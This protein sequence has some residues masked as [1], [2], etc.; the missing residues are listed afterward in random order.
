MLNHRLANSIPRRLRP[1]VR[2]AVVRSRYV[3]LRDQDA[4]LVSYPKSGSTWVRFLLTHA[5][6][7]QETDFD[8]VRRTFPPLG[9]Q[10]RAPSI[11]PGRGRA[12]RTH[13]PLATYRGAPGTPVIYLARDARPVALSYARHTARLLGRPVEPRAFV[14]EF[15]VGAVDSYGP[16]HRHVSDALA[17]GDRRTAPFIVVRFEDLEADTAGTVRRLLAFLGAEP[18]VDVDA[19]VA[20]NAADRM[21]AKEARSDR[22]RRKSRDGS[23]FVGGGGRVSWDEVVPLEQRAHFETVAGRSLRALGYPV[24]PGSMP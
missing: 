8:A 13:E 6:T 2:S 17:F 9:R 3:G 21:R 7:G 11:L 12:V 23:A 1:A 5:L 16:W 18:V 14:A 15:L 4:L 19:V 24:E 22:M 20:A 10:R